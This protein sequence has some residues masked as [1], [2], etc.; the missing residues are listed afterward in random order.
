MER[1]KEMKMKIE[2]NSFGD[3]IYIL[4]NGVTITREFQEGEYA[5][6]VE[7]SGRVY[8]THDKYKDALKSAKQLE[9]KC[10]VGFSGPQDEPDMQDEIN[11]DTNN[12]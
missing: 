4:K 10:V 3:K 9:K 2:F 11:G 1:G 7:S 5:Y 12:E 8:E 6:H